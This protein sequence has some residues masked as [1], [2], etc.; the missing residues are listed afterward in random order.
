M[1]VLAFATTTQ[2]L[3]LPP[4][5]ID[6]ICYVE[7]G[8]NAK[9][10]NINDGGSPSHG[11]C[12]IKLDTAR[13]VGFKGTTKQLMDPKTNIYWAGKYLKHQLR[14][15]DNNIEKAIA[16]YNAG[17]HRVND[18]GLTKNRKYVNKVLQVWL[19]PNINASR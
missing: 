10:V 9:V 12:Q 18:Q 14:R 3:N 17:K 16:A 19:N 4:K 7:S 11:V 15:Y 6:S 13:L 5:L 1:L 8:H 2:T